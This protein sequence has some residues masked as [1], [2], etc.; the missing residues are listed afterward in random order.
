[1]TETPFKTACK[2]IVER[3]LRDESVEISKLKTEVA[4]RYSLEKLPTN[5]EI[6]AAASREQRFYLLPKLRLKPIRSL[7]GV[8]VVAVMTPPCP[9]PHGKCSYCPNIPGVPNS[10]TGKEPSAMRGIQNSYDPY[11]QVHSRI[12]QLVSSGHQVSKVELIVQG[13]TFSATERLTQEQFVKGCLDAITEVPSSSL[14]ES[15]AN[16]EHSMIRNVGMTF[17]TRPDCCREEDVDRMLSL[18]VTRVELGV[19]TIHDDIYRLVERGH[20]VKD[21]TDATQRL[22]DAGLKVCYH[23]MPGL[24]GSDFDRDLSAFE[25]IF[26]NPD[27]MPDMLKIYP[28]LVLEGTKIHEWWMRE[29]YKPYTTEEAVALLSK[30][31]AAVPSWVRIMRVQRDIPAQLIVAGVKKS[32]LR[33]LIH[34]HML[35]HELSCRCIRCREIG[36]QGTTSSTENVVVTTTSYE[37]GGGREFFISAEDPTQDALIAYLRLRTPSS[38]AQ[39]TEI[40][41]ESTAVVRELHVY[42]AIVP[43]DENDPK[44]WQHRGYGKALLQEA[45]KIALKSGIENILVMSAIG[46]RD[47][48]RKQGYQR[49]GPYMGKS[50]LT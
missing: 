15:Q 44:A 35:K 47:Y 36:H 1:M 6:L 41:D 30:V 21:V 24:P 11:S 4:R 2:E 34:E 5:P 9:C 48:F 37:A 18:G 45:E 39:R 23:M 25:E 17:E 7:S 13:G 27:F 12:A 49:D 8:N 32:N 10:Y 40:K 14:S 29:E 19:Q 31:K 28:C 16:A 26:S 50:L 46:A 42:G 3:L 43:V 33:Q 38:K 20:R 22:R